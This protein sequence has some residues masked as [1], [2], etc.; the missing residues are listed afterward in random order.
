MRCAPNGNQALARSRSTSAGTLSTRPSLRLRGQSRGTCRAH[1]RRGTRP[2][3]ARHIHPGHHGVL[4]ANMPD[5][6]NGTV[7]EHP[8]EVRMLALV[9]QIDAGLDGNL[10]AALDQIGELIICQAVEDA[11]RAKI[12]EPASDRRQIAMDQ[13]DRHRAFADGRCNPFHRVEPNVAGCEDSRHARLE[14]EGRP[15]QAASAA[16]STRKRS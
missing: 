2:P 10:S 13:I 5:E 6:I 3:S 15:S 14:R 4:A 8:P 12:I 7:D 16:A 11:Q 9:E 1:P